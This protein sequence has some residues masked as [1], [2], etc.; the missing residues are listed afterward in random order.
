MVT[1]VL[2]SAARMLRRGYCNIRGSPVVGSTAIF[3]RAT[4]RLQPKTEFLKL[5]TLGARVRELVARIG[6]L[7]P[8]A[9]WD[10]RQCRISLTSGVR[11]A[12]QS[13]RRWSAHIPRQQH[14]V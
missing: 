10:R 9:G 4:C 8:A 5:R 6:C 12:V 13:Q 2:S 1:A 7:E 11:R 3:G 14:T